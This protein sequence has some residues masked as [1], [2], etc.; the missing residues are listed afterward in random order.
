MSRRADYL[1]GDLGLSLEDATS[2]QLGIA[3]KVTIT[4]N[5]TTIVA[6]PSMKAEIQARILQIKKDLSESDSSYLSK[7]L[8]ERIA[9]LSGGVAIIRVGLFL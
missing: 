6:D 8:S 7:K 3:R 1:A 9:K 4:S 5:F 2:D